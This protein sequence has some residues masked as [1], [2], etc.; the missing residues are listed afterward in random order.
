MFCLAGRVGR[1]GRVTTVGTLRLLSSNKNVFE[2]IETQKN[3]QKNINLEY[4]LRYADKIA[5]KLEEE[6]ISSKEEFLK[7]K[8]QQQKQA[9]PP[10]QSPQ[11]KR[12]RHIDLDEIVKLDLLEKEDPRTI[13]QIWAKR[14]ENSEFVAGGISGKMHNEL[15]KRGQDCP[16]FILPTPSDTEGQFE[17]KLVQFSLG[18]VAFCSLGEFQI[19]GPDTAPQVVVDFFQELKTKKDLVL[20]RG[21]VEMKRLTVE[22]ARYLMTLLLLFYTG[23]NPELYKFVTNFNHKPNEFS[24]EELVKKLLQIPPHKSDEKF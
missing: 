12:K 7:K 19:H 10:P 3:D 14:H 6:N 4:E 13:L 11:K 9:N 21:N 22:E 5:K 1:V 15:Q 8:R 23:E 17:F 24:H 16:F 18:K 20:F 2:H